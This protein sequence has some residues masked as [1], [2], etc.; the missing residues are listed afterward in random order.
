MCTVCIGAE[1]VKCIYALNVYSVGMM[2][3]LKGKIREITF[4]K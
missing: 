2:K 1:Y 3:F 4:K